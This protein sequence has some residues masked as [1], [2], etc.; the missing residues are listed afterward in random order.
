MQNPERFKYLLELYLSGTLADDQHDEF[1][2]MLNTHEYDELL[3]KQITQDLQTGDHRDSADIPPHIAQDIIRNIYH[4]E[5]HTN[6]LLPKRK[7]FAIG[8]RWMAAASVAL[9]LIAASLFYVWSNE[10]G[11]DSFASLIPGNTNEYKNTGDQ[12]G[13]LTLD[14]GSIVWLAPGS[15]LHYP[16]QF[17]GDKR[18]VYLE[19]E[20]FF[21]VTKNTRQPFLVYYNDIVTKVL[22]T[23]FKIN[24]NGSTGNIE[25]AVRT[26]KVQVYEN[27]MLT[28]RRSTGIAV[29]V[30]P[31][32]KAIYKK[33]NRHF[34]TT[35][36][37]EP[38]SII[39]DAGA[40]GDFSKEA[41]SSF[42]FE[43]EKLLHVFNQVEK[44]YGIEIVTENAAINDCVF[45]GDVSS[46]DLYTK[47]QIICL[48]VNASYEI[49]GTRILIK[50]KGC[51]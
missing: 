44:S 6:Q 5:K 17:A 48:T 9:L 32:Q 24:T 30:T 35:L 41:V 27:E 46:N 11:N 45:T 4:A 7:T 12:P 18:E 13:V 1:F 3:G 39:A 28:E 20:A 40:G 14:D 43:Q 19:G 15:T 49:N 47:L 23:S 50:G 34:E 36:V 37:D 25:V 10:R 38:Q 2:A 16:A 51:K 22:G 26:G 29:I 42:V 21:E 8:R 31:N 33:E